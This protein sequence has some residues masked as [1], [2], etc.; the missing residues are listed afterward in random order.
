MS[1]SSH[2]LY[3]DDTRL[4]LSFS[5]V[6]FSHSSAH[7]EQT[8]SNVYNWISSYFLSLNPSKTEFL[9]IG[10]P[11]QLEK[12]YHPTIHLRNDVILSPVDSARNLGIIFDSNITQSDHK[13]QNHACITFEISDVSATPLVVPQRVP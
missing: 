11:K 12:L 3:A 8:V 5:A 7:L 10:L 2:K 9:V 13:C 1:S 6:D 4:H